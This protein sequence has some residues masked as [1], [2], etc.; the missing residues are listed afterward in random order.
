M[1]VRVE[2]E[3]ASFRRI[4]EEIFRRV[5]QGEWGPGTLLPNEID[6]AAEFGCSRATVNRSLRELSEAG[7]IDRKRKAGTRVRLTPLREARFQIPLVKTEIEAGGAIYDY[8][9]L[10]RQMASPPAWLSTSLHLKSK[11][12]LLHLICLHLADG[13]P[14]QLEDRWINVDALP[15]AL[16]ID[17]TAVSPNDWLVSTIPYS[18]VEISFFAA[19]AGRLES[20]Y[21]GCQAGEPVFTA[22]RMTWWETK[23]ITHVRLSFR[24]GYRMTTRY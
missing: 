6:L 16:D 4:K 9:L 13:R 19:A 3:R 2:G 23:P 15:Q 10:D 5:T 18:E 24:Q 1:N 12:K 21:L 14:Y 8:R 11:K 20:D 17:F 7:L 22:E